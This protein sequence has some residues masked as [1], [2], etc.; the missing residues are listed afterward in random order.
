MSLDARELSQVVAELAPL[1]GARLAEVRVHAEKALT[2]ELSTP[3]GAVHLLLSAEPDA[4]RLHAA[5]HRYPRPD[6]PFP[7]QVV[8]RRELAGARLLSLELS[9]GDRVVTLAFAAAGGA[10]RLVAE[11]TGR[12]GNLLLVGDD[13]LVRAAAGRDLSQRRD[14]VP[15]QPYVPPGSPGPGGPPRDR[16]TPVAGARFPLSAAIERH[17]LALEEEKRLEAGRKRLRDPVRA[18]LARLGRALEKLADEAARVPAAEEDRRVADLLKTSL[19]R[20]KRGQAS[21]TV[22]EWTEQGPREVVV[23][24]DPALTPQANMERAY[25]RYRRIVES[26][27]RVAARTDEVRAKVAALQALL[28]ELDGAEAGELPRLEREARK[29]GAGPRPPPRPKQRRDEAPGLPYRSFRSLAGVAILVGKG[30]A[31]NDTLTK[32]HARGNDLW[33]HARGVP[34]SHVVV[35]V[36]KGPGPDQETLLDAAHLA[37]HFSD[38]RGAPVAD[39]A[40]TRVKYVKK[41]RGAA[42]GAVEYH[43]EKVLGLRIEPG[44]VERLLAE[45]EPG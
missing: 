2:L 8:L 18:G 14:L 7:F 21:V 38:A 30:A 27:A 22:T 25:K 19:H 37:A 32:R 9:P 39:V 26:A 34:G 41:P 42:P 13:G 16:F 20:V 10:R 11:L 43:Q 28:S 12:H 3:A 35:R 17:H 24:L 36:G 29:L 4:T 1:A 31:Q 23:G 45:E 44:R 40:W 15:G 5:S 6:E 33:L